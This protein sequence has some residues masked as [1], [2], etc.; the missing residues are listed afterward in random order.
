M[1]LLFILLLLTLFYCMQAQTVTGSWYGKAEATSKGANNNNY[2]TELII[3][4]KGNEVEGI[5]GYYF[6]SGYQSYYIRGK[7]NPKTRLLTIKNL[8]VTYFKSLDIDGIE[9]PM[10]FSAILFASKLQSTLSGAFVSQEKYKYTC[11]Q[12]NFSYTL[13][14]ND[15]SQDSLNRNSATVK[16]YWKPRNEEL[17]INTSNISAATAI[18]ERVTTEIKKDSAEK[19]AIDTARKKDLEKLVASFVQRKNILSNVVEI[20]SDSV[21]VSL[22]DNGDIDG[23]SISLFINK[24]PVL[25]HQPLSERALN[26]YL[27]MDSAHASTEITMYAENLGLY[28]P[29]TALMVIT[30]GAKRH[31]V[32]LSSSLTQNSSVVLKRKKR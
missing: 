4:Q 26:I 15:K 12:L 18:P 23:D 17:V 28:P 32:F 11:P 14:V 7:Y 5:F 25:T 16:K 2:L 10:D 13:D 19:K 3:T 30:D 6:R 21:R 8:P 20:E 1:R 27:A 22:Y 24:V 31:E 9:C 29:N